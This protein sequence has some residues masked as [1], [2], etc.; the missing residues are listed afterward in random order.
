MNPDEVDSKMATLQATL[1]ALD[2]ALATIRRAR[3]ASANPTS[4]GIQP[5]GLIVAPWAVSGMTVATAKV[6]SARAEV[7]VLVRG[8]SAEITQQRVASAVDGGS[9]LGVPVG[10]GAKAEQG[11]AP[12]GGE[13][14][15]GVAAGSGT[16]AIFG[17]VNKVYSGV[18]GAANFLDNSPLRV[19]QRNMTRLVF[20]TKWSA[21]PRAIHLVDEAFKSPVGQLGTKAFGVV[22]SGFAINNFFQTLNDPASTSWDKTRDGVAM[23]L[24]V[25]STVLLF[26][27]AAPV[28]LAVVAAA[29][30]AWAVGSAIYD[31]R[32]AIGS[33]IDKAS[34]SVTET[35]SKAAAVVTETASR[36]AARVVDR[37]QSFFGGISHGLGVAWP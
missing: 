1:S 27:P 29:G 22:G 30:L 17:A 18:K 35:A 15:A 20:S 25:A 21:V 10:S 24:T 33:F 34:K 5:G 12:G 28:V 3:D 31:N 13:V 23:G 4:Y 37:A 32:E 8:L 6:S 11:V 26:T 14:D 19:V 36:V 7:E 2:G 16:A 9:G